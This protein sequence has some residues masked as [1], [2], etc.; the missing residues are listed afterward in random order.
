[1]YARVTTFH[2]KPGTKDETIQAARDGPL[3]AARRENGFKGFFILVDPEGN[4]GFG[5]TLWDSEGDLHASE[6]ARGYYDEQMARMSELLDGSPTRE[7]YEV[8]L[9]EMES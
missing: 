2:T 1:M 9:L 6:G 5:I 7:V 3:A 4:S 8:A